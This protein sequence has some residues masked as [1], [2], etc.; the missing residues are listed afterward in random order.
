MTASDSVPVQFWDVDEET[1]NEKVVCGLIKQDCFCQ[2]FQCGDEIKIQIQDEVGESF[3]LGIYDSEGF[4]LQRLDFEEVSDGYYEVSFVPSDEF[5]PEICQKIQLKIEALELGEWTLQQSS[6]NASWQSVC[7]GNGIFVAVG[8]SGRAM[9]SPDGITWTT[10]STP[11]SNSWE[12][13]GFGNGLFV[14]AS[15][16]GTGN[17]VMTSPDGETWTSR[18]SASDS[19]WLSVAYG[20]GL[21]VVVGLAVVMTSNDGITWTSRTPASVES[22]AGVIYCT[23]LGLFVSVAVSGSGNQVMTSPD[24]VN[25]T[26]RT[27]PGAGSGWTSIT[28]GNGLLVAVAADDHPN[29]IMTS[30]DAVTWTLRTTPFNAAWI[31]VTFGNGLF[32]AVPEEEVGRI[33]FSEDG[34]VWQQMLSQTLLWRGIAFDDNRFVAVGGTSGSGGTNQVIT[35]D[36]GFE[37]LMQSD[38]LDLKET[39]ECTKLIEYENTSNFDG[40]DYVGGSPGPSFQLRIP[41]IF[42]E[43][44]NPQEQE[45]AE[46]SNGQIITLRQSI[47]EKRLLEIGYLPPYMH[48]KIQKVLMHDSVLIDGDYWRKRDP[49]EPNP[50]KKYNLKTASVMLTKYDS[51]EKNTI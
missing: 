44:Q 31:S 12:A 2:P 32:V 14:A 9:T 33:M 24:G 3:E 15:S 40:I 42:F 39:H 43:E 18:T 5:S 45:D 10:R 6:I 48:R 19:T 17:R 8:A 21:F 28:Y 38:C 13:I 25:W 23:D 47:Q 4:E 1:F 34:I 36:I 26:T 22:W 11:N 16:N 20:N 7:F 46:L 41:A 35:A 29:Q 37:T 51:V 30:P 50:I 27:T 49:Y